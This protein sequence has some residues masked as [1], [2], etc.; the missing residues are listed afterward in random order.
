MVSHRFTLQSVDVAYSFVR[1]SEMKSSWY[2]LSLK[3]VSS[4][5]LLVFFAAERNICYIAKNLHF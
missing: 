2:P 3:L 1:C 5:P 4:V